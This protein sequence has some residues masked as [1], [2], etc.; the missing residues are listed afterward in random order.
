MGILNK[1]SR[2]TKAWACYCKDQCTYLPCSIQ[3]GY[4]GCRSSVCMPHLFPIVNFVIVMPY[5]IL[6]HKLWP[7]A[8]ANTWL[9]SGLELT[10]KGVSWNCVTIYITPPTVNWVWLSYPYPSTTTKVFHWEWHQF[11][12]VASG[13]G[14]YHHIRNIS[15]KYEKMGIKPRTS[16]FWRFAIRQN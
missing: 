15:L 1:N 13:V 10:I 8:G 3:W 9:P 7:N 16:Y 5:L 6:Y 12:Y 4:I 14:N 11:L 2:Y